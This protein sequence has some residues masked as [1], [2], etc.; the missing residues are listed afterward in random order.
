MRQ[1]AAAT[2]RYTLKALITPAPGQQQASVPSAEEFRV[3]AAQ[4]PANTSNGH[5]PMG[6]S[7]R[8]RRGLQTLSAESDERCMH[9]AR[10]EADRVRL[11]AGGLGREC[12][13]QTTTA[14]HCA[15]CMRWRGGGARRP[16]ANACGTTQLGLPRKGSRSANDVSCSLVGRSKKSRRGWSGGAT[17]RFSC[18]SAA[19]E[20]L[21]PR[22][23][24]IV[25]KRLLE[26]RRRDGPD[27]ARLIVAT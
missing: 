23:P 5:A 16:Q 21:N 19:K 14:A 24:T 27:Q 22:L 17:A 2:A 3:T 12:G 13:L 6:Q 11:R 7:G 18:C 4:T 26:L 9:M 8:G 15:G 1:P 20:W 10:F 25:R